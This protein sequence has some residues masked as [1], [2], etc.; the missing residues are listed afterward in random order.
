VSEFE[1]ILVVAWVVVV[2]MATSGG[3]FGNLARTGLTV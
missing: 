3:R 1:A 2:L